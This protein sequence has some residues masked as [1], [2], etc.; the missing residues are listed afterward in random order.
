MDFCKFCSN[1][2]QVNSFCKCRFSSCYLPLTKVNATQP[3]NVPDVEELTQAPAPGKAVSGSTIQHN[4]NK[5]QDFE[6]RL[7]EGYKTK[8]TEICSGFGVCCFS[9]IAACGGTV[10]QNQT[11]LRNPGYTGQWPEV[12]GR[13]LFSYKSPF[14]PNFYP[15]LQIRTTQRAHAATRSAR[16]TRRASLIIVLLSFF[17]GVWF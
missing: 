1:I 15:I 2:V 17:I 12:T 14:L 8:L 6:S 3:Q 5:N 4:T 9:T 11:Y 13:H 7:F 10:T 16:P